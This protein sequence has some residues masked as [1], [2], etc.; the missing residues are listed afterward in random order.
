L[1]K[2]HDSSEIIE[3]VEHALAADIGSGAAIKHMLLKSSTAPMPALSGWQRLSPPDVSVY[4]QIGG[5]I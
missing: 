4:G 3:A 2:D 5:A 1:F